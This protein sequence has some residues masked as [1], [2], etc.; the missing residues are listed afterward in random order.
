M[1]NPFSLIN[2]TIVITGAS[3][4]IGRQCAVTADAMGA[5][6]ILIARSLEGL[7]KTGALCSQTPLLISSDVTDYAKT[8][9]ELKSA[10]D[11][12]G[13]IDGIIHA[14]GIS[15][16]LPLKNITPEK[17]EPF[18]QT[19]VYAGINITKLVTKMGNYNKEG[20]SVVFIASVMGIVGELGKT[21]YSLTK[22]ALVAGTRSLSLELASK[23]IRVNCI[24][25]GVVESPMSSNAV[26]AQD[27]EAFDKIKSYH[28]LGLGKP[29]DIANA[30]VY[31]LSDASRWV[32]GT[33]LIVDGGYTAR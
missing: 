29:E 5:K 14:A 3:S 23:N 19:N 10:I 16:T 33:T 28:P 6:L 21:I 7:Q 9:H 30:C 31:L 12:V 32:T 27:K 18:F 22:G 13:K 2:K 8:E 1:Q 26:Y 20:L 4:G 11:R 24:A 15:T 25:P 17:L